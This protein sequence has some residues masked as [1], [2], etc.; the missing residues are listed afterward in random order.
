M[1]IVIVCNDPQES[2]I[3]GEFTWPE[4]VEVFFPK[5]NE[6]YDFEGSRNVYNGLSMS[7][8]P[9]HTGLLA[10]PCGQAMIK[11]GYLKDDG[12]PG[13]ST[14][15]W[16]QDDIF[17]FD[18]PIYLTPGKPVTRIAINLAEHSGL[19]YSAAFF[20]TEHDCSMYLWHDGEWRT[21][22]IPQNMVGNT[23]AF[24]QYGYYSNK[25]EAKECLLRQ[26]LK[27]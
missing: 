26:L 7:N 11:Y 14:D 18:K 1:A 13:I 8:N 24:T 6:I 19:Y 22:A 27:S 2:Q 15:A 12:T 23:S 21:S 3:S 5:Y 9:E 20:A 16:L 4:N 10:F 25:Q 17:M